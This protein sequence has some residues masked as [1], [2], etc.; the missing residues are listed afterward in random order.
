VPQLELGSQ[1]VEGLPADGAEARIPQSLEGVEGATAS[2]LQSPPPPLHSFG[3][4]KLLEVA[5]GERRRAGRCGVG[6]GAYSVRALASVEMVQQGCALLV[7]LKLIVVDTGGVARWVLVTPWGL[8]AGLYFC[9]FDQ[10]CCLHHLWSSGSDA[11]VLPVL[12]EGGL[13]R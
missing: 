4:L 13:A 3:P 12:G 5:S 9:F 7:A 11:L 2:A 8:F 6:D 10:C 1:L